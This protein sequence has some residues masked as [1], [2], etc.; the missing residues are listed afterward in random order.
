MHCSII[1][2]SIP[3]CENKILLVKNKGKDFWYP[4]GGGLEPGETL[5]EGAIRETFEET[6]MNVRLIRL[7]WVKQYI[8]NE[9]EILVKFIWLSEPEDIN[10]LAI[11]G[12]IN[13]PLKNDEDLEMLRWFTQEELKTINVLPLECR[14]QLWN[15]ALDQILRKHNPILTAQT[16]HDHHHPS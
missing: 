6:G 15:I 2:S 5:E 4:P 9:N 10:K 11:N 1:T 7:L 3:M 13:T 12:R 8:K 16:P 14:D